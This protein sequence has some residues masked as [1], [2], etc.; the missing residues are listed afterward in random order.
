MTEESDPWEVG[1]II[2]LRLLEAMPRTESQL[3]DALLKRGLPDEVADGLVA[4]YVEVGLLDDEAY[5]R[6]WVESR[7]RTRGLG[8]MALRQELRTRGVPDHVIEEA[9]A[10]VDPDDAFTAAVSQVR[11]RVA[12]CQLQLS[13]GDERRLLAFLARRGHST[14][15]ARRAVR[16]AVEEVAEAD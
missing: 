12:R 3:R 11:P 10:D 13:A 7:M 1:R 4:R 8:R 15:T 9:L 2:A 5:A 16:V 14:D 6:M